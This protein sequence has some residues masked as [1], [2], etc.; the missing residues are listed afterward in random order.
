MRTNSHVNIKTEIKLQKAIHHSH[1]AKLHDYFS[2]A[3]NIYIVLEYC[4]SGNLG[5]YLK[6]NSRL[7]EGEAVI[8]FLQTAFAV[9]YLHTNNIMHRDL[10]LENLL[11][12]SKGNLKLSDFGWSAINTTR[13][14]QTYCGTLDYMAP[15]M[16]Q[17]RQYDS[18]VDIWSL[19]VLLFELTQGNIV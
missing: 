12:D 2:D 1:I 18:K 17:G 11:L 7:T 15:E 9:E 19:G 6:R 8:Y 10:K 16:V 3:D 14:R 5:E 13:L 4:K